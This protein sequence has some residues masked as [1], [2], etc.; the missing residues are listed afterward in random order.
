MNWIK[1]R[2]RE[3]GLSQEELA[4]RLSSEGYQVSRGT[5]AHWEQ[6][7][8]HPPLDDPTLVNA[9]ARAFN[10]SVKQILVEVGFD[11]TDETISKDELILLE[12]FEAIPPERRTTAINILKQL[13]DN[14]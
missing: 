7:R 3:L 8:Y 4:E 14:S 6:D 10:I 2:R 5:V 12:V 11:L 13:V 9:L 1:T